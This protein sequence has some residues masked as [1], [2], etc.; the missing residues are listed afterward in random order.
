MNATP[1]KRSPQAPSISLDDA[2]DRAI[3]IY[4][5]ERRHASPSAVIAVNLGYKDA[6]S[7]PAMQTLASLRYF[8]LIERPQEGMIAVTK[9]V[10]EYKFSPSDSMR[11]S[12]IIKWLT[13][14]P[15]FNELL[16]KYTTGLPSEATLK[17]DLIKRGFNPITAD[18]FLKVFIRSV[19][20][21]RY[22]DEIQKSE[23]NPEVE[24]NDGLT[25]SENSVNTT[26]QN[27]AP[28]NKLQNSTENISKNM[29]RFLVRLS[30]GRRG[31]IEVPIPFFEA[32]K[33]RLKDQIDLILSDDDEITN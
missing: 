33:K 21:A 19:D 7:G 17:F 14:P 3:R 9:E 18:S 11:K 31:W 1:R 25:H 20:Y 5:K 16:Q 6:T 13:A 2:I 23:V 12:Q 28:Q 29:D 27:I 24:A 22:Y 8:G 26:T 15:I 32:D 4:D 30:G 10:E